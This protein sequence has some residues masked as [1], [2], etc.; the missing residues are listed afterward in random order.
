MS[1]SMSNVHVMR[2]NFVR[3]MH[4]RA[5]CVRDANNSQY[6]GRCCRVCGC[7]T[8]R[9]IPVHGPAQDKTAGIVCVDLG[10]L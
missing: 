8:A 2:H 4:V 6:H 10:G 1:I 5:A 7:A 3:V 9:F